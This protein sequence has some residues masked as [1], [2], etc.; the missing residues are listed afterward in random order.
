MNCELWTQNLE[1]YPFA[2]LLCEL[3]GVMSF[4]CCWG[5]GGCA[6]VERNQPRRKQGKGEKRERVTGEVSKSSESTGLSFHPT[7]I[8][9][10]LSGTLRPHLS[11]SYSHETYSCLILSQFLFGLF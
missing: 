4:E 8:K 5:E 6:S 7:P 1:L 10:G 11:Y 3:C 2:P 9:L